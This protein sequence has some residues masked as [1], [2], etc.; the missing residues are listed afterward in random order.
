MTDLRMAKVRSGIARRGIGTLLTVTFAALATLVAGSAFLCE[1]AVRISPTYRPKPS[2]TLAGSVAHDTGASWEPVEITAADGVPLRGWW[3]T[4]RNPSGR[5]AILLH[6]VGDARRGVL[7]QARFLLRHDFA[8]LAPDSRGHGVSGGEFIT[9]GVKE[10][11]DIHRWADWIAGPGH[12]EKL[13]GLGESMGAGILLESLE[14][15]PRFR[16]VVAECPFATFD[17]VAHYRV[18][19]VTGLGRVPTW[20]LVRGAFLYARAAHHLD[21]SGASPARVVRST[22]VPILLI[23]GTAD[24]NIPPSHSRELHAVNP[25]VTELW[26]VPGAVHVSAMW[27]QPEEYEKKVIAWFDR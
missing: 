23:H 11:D 16:A 4:P 12:S 6:G 8:V 2:S 26:E 27:A 5:A 7:G 13:Y 18:A 10:A 20:P 21:F 22:H 14:V 15:E 24:V 9:Y 25:Q 17:E 3:F 1:N 19:R